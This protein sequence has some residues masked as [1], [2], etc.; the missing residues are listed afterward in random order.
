[1][2]QCAEGPENLLGGGGLD[3][4]DGSKE[5]FVGTSGRKPDSE[6]VSENG[7]YTADIKS[8]FMKGRKST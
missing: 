3:L 5:V 8:S 6:S 1:M 2:R 7:T 4:S